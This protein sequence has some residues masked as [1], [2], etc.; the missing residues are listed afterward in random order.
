MHNADFSS[1]H[2][3]LITIIG[4]VLLTLLGVG[5]RLLMMLTIQQ[6]R[7]RLNRQI[8]ERVKTLIAAYKTLGGSF[9]GDLS[10]SPLHLKDIK[11][12]NGDVPDIASLEL[13]GSS[14]RARRIR[15]AVESA[16][17]D[18]I[19][20]GTEE[21]VRLAVR[22]ASELAQGRNVH[23]HDLVVALRDFIRK[24][25]DIERIPSDLEL[26][27]QGPSRPSGGSGGR[28]K[29][30]GSQDGGGKGGG[31]AGGMGGGGMGGTMGGGLSADGDAD[32]S[33]SHHP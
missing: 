30:A 12:R 8:N 31:G 32:T 13:S 23:T 21:H 33:T 28:E 26:P 9:T 18:I 3:T 19:L 22:A 5:V 29:G 11:E 17:S 15:D 6:R 20:L 7:E 4:L 16:L 10:V 25:L 2:S 1:W 27:R 14:E 24:A